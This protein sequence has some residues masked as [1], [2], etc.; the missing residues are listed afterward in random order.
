VFC[1]DDAVAIRHGLPAP[2]RTV[3]TELLHVCMNFAVNSKRAQH[4]L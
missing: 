1:V 3:M 4:A 2:R